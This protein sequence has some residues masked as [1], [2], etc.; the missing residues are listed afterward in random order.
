MYTAVSHW[1]VSPVTSSMVWSALAS[2]VPE[3]ASS[4]ATLDNNRTIRRKTISF[5]LVVG[6]DPR[7][8]LRA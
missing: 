5:F 1:N 8:T 2:A 4:S 7:A 3:S 6:A